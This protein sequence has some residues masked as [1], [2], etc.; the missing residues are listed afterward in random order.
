MAGIDLG[1]FSTPL[2]G[3]SASLPWARAEA[4]IDFANTWTKLHGNHT[5][6]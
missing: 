1:D 2:T 3:Y 6:T 4:N 5:F